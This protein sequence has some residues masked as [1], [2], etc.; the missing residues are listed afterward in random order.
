MVDAH[1]LLSVLE[2]VFPPLFN[3]SALR[4]RP[5]KSWLDRLY[6]NESEVDNDDIDKTTPFSEQ[7]ETRRSKPSK[8]DF[9]KQKKRQRQKQ[10]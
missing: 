7:L 10:Q 5:M 3:L 8:S 6:D 2:T 4:K 9:W 1:F